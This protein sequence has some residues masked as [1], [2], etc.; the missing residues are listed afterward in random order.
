MVWRRAGKAGEDE[1]RVE[2]NDRVKMVDLFWGFGIDKDLI[3]NDG[4][5]AVDE[6]IFAPFFLFFSFLFLFSLGRW[7]RRG[8]RERE[9]R[10]Y[11]HGGRWKGAFY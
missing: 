7:W 1:C 5:A 2:G 10:V 8:R 11:V 6:A 3:I 9:L 4:F